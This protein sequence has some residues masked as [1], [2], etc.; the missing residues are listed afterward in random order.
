MT[1]DG[2][3]VTELLAVWNERKASQGMSAS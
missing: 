3:E 2:V 1:I